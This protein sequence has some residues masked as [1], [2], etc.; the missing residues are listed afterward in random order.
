ML[1]KSSVKVQMI[2]IRFDPFFDSPEQLAASKRTSDSPLLDRRIRINEVRPKDQY[3][4]VGVI[5][6][7]RSFRDNM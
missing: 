3:F 4:G 2:I 7:R 5:A 1:T 6:R